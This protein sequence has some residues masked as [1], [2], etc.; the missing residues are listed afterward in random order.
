MGFAVG[1]Y[2]QSNDAAFAVAF[3]FAAEDGAAG[4]VFFEGLREAVL[5]VAAVG[6]SV[7]GAAGKD[8]QGGGFFAV[9]GD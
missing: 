8:E 7:G 9:A 4:R 1:L 6:G 3:A 5:H 2:F